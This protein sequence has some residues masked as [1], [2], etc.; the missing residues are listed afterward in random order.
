MFG[1]KEFVLSTKRSV[2]SGR[3]VVTFESSLATDDRSAA[4]DDSFVSSRTNCGRGGGVGIFSVVRFS[5]SIISGFAFGC[6]CRCCCEI[7]S[8]GDRFVT[9]VS[10]RSSNS[11][12]SNDNFTVSLFSLFDCRSDGGVAFSILSD[13]F[14]S[15]PDETSIV[16]FVTVSFG[17][18]VWTVVCLSSI[19]DVGGDLV[20]SRLTDAKEVSLA[21]LSLVSSIVATLRDDSIESRLSVSSIVC[22]VV[23]FASSWIVEEL[24]TGTSVWTPAVS[25]FNSSKTFD[26]FEDGFEASSSAI[27]S[28]ISST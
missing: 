17:S 19:V 6:C 21:V 11:F 4:T 7:S 12:F 1:T 28:S 10:V 26:K 5:I 16:G 18:A 27:A 14:V 20:V 2:I 15:V 8:V 3:I 24:A 25:F 23:G 9:V 13:E 22:L